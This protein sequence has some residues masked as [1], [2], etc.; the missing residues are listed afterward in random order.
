MGHFAHHGSAAFRLLA[1]YYLRLDI[2]GLQPQAEVG[3]DAEKGLA[4]DNERRN[5]EDEIR[6]QIMNV[7]PIIEH[8]ATDEWM[9]GKPQSADKVGEVN[10]PFVRFRRRDDLPRGWQLV[11][12][13]CG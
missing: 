8:K 1:A 13:I 10:H 4:Q 11:L 7:Q 9:E 2:E 5:V 6:G 3:L 12:D